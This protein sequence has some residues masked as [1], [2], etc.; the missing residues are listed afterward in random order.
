[1]TRKTKTYLFIG[2]AIAFY[3]WKKKHAVAAYPMTIAP[4]VI[5]TLQAPPLSPSVLNGY[6]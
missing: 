3:M 6:Y 5:G 1:M 2:A 4:P